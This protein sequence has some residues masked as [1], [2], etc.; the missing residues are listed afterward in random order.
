MTALRTLVLSV[1]MF[2]SLLTTV[3]VA[4]AA[5]IFDNGPPASGPT[6]AAGSDAS[7]ASGAQAADNFS[8]PAGQTTIHDAHWFGVYGLRDTPPATDDFTL[9]I[10]ADDSGLPGDLVDSRAV[11]NVSRTPTGISFDQIYEYSTDIAPIALSAGTTYWFSVMNNTL[12]STTFSESW[13]W[14]ASNP[15]DGD[16]AQRLSPGAEWLPR[17]FELAFKLTDVPEP[18]TLLLLGAGLAGLAAWRRRKI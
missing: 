15:N 16:A 14:S 5:V 4:P 13:F 17:D 10:Y 3:S 11:G 8:L 9:F 7:S 18:S 6:I 1:T 12:D 2:S